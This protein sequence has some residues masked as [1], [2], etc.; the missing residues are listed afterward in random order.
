MAQDQTFY[1]R[2]YSRLRIPLLKR[3]GLD[4]ASAELVEKAWSEGISLEYDRL[5]AQGVQCGFG[6]LGLCCRNCY[7]G[8]C[9]I[10]PFG[11]GPT[12]GVCGADADTIVARNLVREEAGGAAS[13]T[14]HAYEVA[15]TLLEV[16]HGRVKAYSISDKEKLYRIAE[17]LGI[18]TRGKTLEEVA[19][20]VAEKALE[21]FRR[22]N[23]EPMNW[24]KA[25]TPKSVY[26]VWEKLGL[27]V[28]NAFHEITNAM[29]RTTMGND[30]DPVNLLLAA[31]RLGIVDGYAG[32]HLATD[33]QDVL[34]GTPKP[35]KVVTSLGV[36]KADH[37]NIA[38]H[39]HNPLLSMKVVEWA[40]KLEGEARKVGAA[41]INVVGICCTGNEVLM[42]LGV[43]A[44]AHNAQ[45]ELAIVTGALDAMVVDIQCIFPSLAQVASCYHTKLITTFPYAKIPGALHIE[46]TPEKADEVAERIVREAIEAFKRRDRSK[47]YI[48]KKVEE[49]IVGFSVE[50]ILDVL[51]KIN[52]EDPLKPLV[53]VIAEG[54]VKGAV[55][56]VGCPNPKLRD[57]RVTE[58]LAKALIQRDILVVS[59][60]CTAIAMAQEGLMKPEATERYAGPGLKA[61]LKTLGEAAGLGA[62]LPPVWHMG[63]CVDNS[64]IADLISA[65]SEK[66][67]VH[68]SKLPVAGSAPEFITEK[69]VSIGTYFLALGIP[70]HVA[71]A[72]RIYGSKVVAEILTE[73]LKELTGGQLIVEYDPDAAAEKLY[74]IILEKR[75]ELGLPA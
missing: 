55:G 26:E 44:A 33:L 65:L 62:S 30:A 35:I 29:H 40:R 39:G 15:H 2:E 73:K 8:P 14:E 51:R 57:K 64:R 74:N 38:V 22:I 42:R 24:L 54:K 20:L 56:I 48:P 5:E 7:M 53:D 63:S 19:A 68:P 1:E 23:R 34:F 12:R 16:A 43:P 58:R 41:G 11:E 60:G 61:V 67:G 32:L 21:D 75:K 52:P 66:L 9:R 27:L 45:A 18:D 6:L 28:S 4:E 72:P 59:T 17:R 71:P 69:A 25:K 50:A 37:V 13:H 36:L 31:L 49:A 70:V 46:F 10:D 47:I 3:V